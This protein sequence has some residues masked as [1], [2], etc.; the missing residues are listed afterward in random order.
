MRSVIA[1]PPPAARRACLVEPADHAAVEHRRGRDRAQAEAIDRLQASRCR[2]GGR[3]HR[4]RRA[5]P[6]HARASGSPPTAWQASARHSLSTCRPGRRAAEVVIEGDDA[7]HLG[8]GDVQAPRRS[9]VP[10]LRRYSRTPPARRAGSAAADLRDQGSPECTQ[11]RPPYS[12]ELIY[13]KKLG[14]VSRTSGVPFVVRAISRIMRLKYVFYSNYKRLSHQIEYRRSAIFR[15]AGGLRKLALALRCS[16]WSAG[17]LAHR[18]D[19]KSCNT[20]EPDITTKK[21]RACF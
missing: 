5:G 16:R 8:A 1:A 2:P 19:A 4:A 12:R 7:V 20:R 14:L 17:L 11:A 13:S 21:A 10:R 18:N 15:S 9:A 3:A 6:R